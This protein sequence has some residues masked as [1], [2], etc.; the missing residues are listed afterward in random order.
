MKLCK[1][2]IYFFGE[3][4]SMKKWLMLMGLVLTVVLIVA[5]CGSAADSGGDQ[6]QQAATG[7]TKEITIAST[8]FE[9][10]PKEIR[11][12][13]GDSV[14]I[15]LDNKQGMHAVKFAGYNVEVQPGKTV[16]FVADKAGEFKYECSIMC[17]AG[18][19]DM[20]GTLIVE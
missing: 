18:H 1:K 9:F 11:V 5:G 19:K 17:G 12:K 6:E 8:N 14:K 10:D 16:T 7:E 13:K 4:T 15:T 20:V 3:E 2:T